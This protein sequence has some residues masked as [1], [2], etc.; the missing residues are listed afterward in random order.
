MRTHT[1]VSLNQLQGL[2]NSLKNSG[3]SLSMSKKRKKVTKNPLISSKVKR[4]PGRPRITET[5]VSS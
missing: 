4:G 5:V 3:N 2:L 1:Q